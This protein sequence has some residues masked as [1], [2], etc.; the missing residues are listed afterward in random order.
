MFFLGFVPA[1]LAIFIRSGI[2][3]SPVWLERRGRQ[4]VREK[5]RINPAVVQGWAFMAFVNFMLWATFALY[6]TFLISVRHLDPSGVFPYVAIYSV[7][8]IVGKP[9]AGHLVERFGERRTLVPYLL[10]TIPSTLLY[11]LINNPVAL[12]IGAVLMGLVANSVFG[13][14]PMY[15][16][17]R[18]PAARRGVGVGIGYAMTSLSVGAPYAVALVTPIWGLAASMAFFIA[19]AALI[20]AALAALNTERWIAETAHDGGS[21]AS[22]SLSAPNPK[23]ASA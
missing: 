20:S 2:K 18:F 21:P 11:T 12:A 7:A 23:G 6:P 5:L 15:L 10:L 13:I 9:L 8:S 19:V 16:A 4:E 1:L 17:R 14:V 22:G 3:E